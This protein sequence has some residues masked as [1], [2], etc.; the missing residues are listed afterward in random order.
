MVNFVHFLKSLDVFIGWSLLQQFLHVYFSIAIFVET[1]ISIIPCYNN[2]MRNKKSPPLLSE[3]FKEDMNNVYF[4]FTEDFLQSGTGMS[5]LK[6]D[7]LCKL[8]TYF[9]NGFKINL[10]VTDQENFVFLHC[11]FFYLSQQ[12][13]SAI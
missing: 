12:V 7:D 1:R 13:L 9:C 8:Y 5:S 2:K 6:Q 3:E 11:Q 10:E 4:Y